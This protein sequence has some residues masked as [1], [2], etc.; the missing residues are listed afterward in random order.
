MMIRTLATYEWTSKQK[1]VGAR[2]RRQWRMRPALLALEERTLLSTIVVNNPTDTPVIGQTDLRQAI[3]QANTV[4]GTESI[5]FDKTVFAVENNSTATICNTN[6]LGN[7]AQGGAGGAGTDGGDGI[8]GGIASAIGRASDTSSVSLTKS[9]LISNVA[10]GGKGGNGANGGNGEGGGIFVGAAGGA[11]LDQT[12]VLLD[13]ALAGLAGKGGDNGDSI[14]GGLYVTTGGVVTLHR[15]TV[16]LNFAST[17]NGNIH[18]A[19]S[20]V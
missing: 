1:T 8:G 5:S 14:G 20:Y 13:F 11:A 2:K 10:Q 17:S 9:S 16:A 6:F 18:G 19:V 3:V 15:T 4:E 7:L 12:N